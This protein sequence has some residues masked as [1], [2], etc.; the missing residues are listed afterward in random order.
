MNADMTIENVLGALL[1]FPL[2]LGIL[3]AIL[4]GIHFALTLPMRKAERTRLFLDLVEMAV[5]NGQPVEETLISISH[6][7]GDALGVRFHQFAAWLEDGASFT[8]AL[9][10]VPQFLPPKIRSM[11]RAGLH[12]GDL[13]KVLP[14]CRQL[15]RDAVS[16]RRGAIY[17]IFMVTLFTLPVVGVILVLVVPKLHEIAQMCGPEPPWTAFVL[18]HVR[19]LL[20]VQIALLVGLLLA[21]FLSTEGSRVARW[22]SILDRLHYHLPWKRKRMQRDF[23]T[24]LGILLESG[25]PEPDAVRLAADSTANR[26]FRRR[27][28]RVIARLAQGVSLPEAIQTLDDTGEFG[29]RL[30]NAFHTRANFVLSLAGW[31]ES[32]DA[33]AFQQQHAAEHVVTTA[34]ILW[35][36]VFVGMIVTS[37]F[38]LLIF[39]MNT[40]GLW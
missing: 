1:V 37:I 20:N 39:I 24:M 34:L 32:L 3:A 36:G 31:H 29:W 6:H 17:Y 10:K 28:E 22:F 35:N 40:E 8:A 38:L 7:Q 25:V 13:R 4:S 2:I 33:K 9:D 23:S 14:A 18:E 11:L 26:V 15:L 12:Q 27:A 21:D 30:R 19:Q 5:E 16:E